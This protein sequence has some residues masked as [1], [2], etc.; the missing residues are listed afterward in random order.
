VR[1]HCTHP[2]PFPSPCACGHGRSPPCPRKATS[3][4]ARRDFPRGRSGK[5]HPRLIVGLRQ[6]WKRCAWRAQSGSS[7]RGNAGYSRSPQSARHCCGGP[8][9]AG[10][11]RGLERQRQ[12]WRSGLA[13]MQP[14]GAPKA[15]SPEV[16]G[17]LSRQR[18]PGAQARTRPR[19]RAE[20]R[21]AGG[22]EGG[23]TGEKS[24][25]NRVRTS[26][27]T[28]PPEAFLLRRWLTLSQT[29]PPRL[30]IPVTRA[31]WRSAPGPR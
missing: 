29:R 2:D 26:V 9:I 30:P 15:R 16:P 12:G 28:G 14:A 21:T 22:Q 17:I 19:K 25:I 23:W 27:R 11:S 6:C 31:T 10:R 18:L 20:P 3:G 13:R 5:W 1:R 7:C 24:E 4:R 8:R